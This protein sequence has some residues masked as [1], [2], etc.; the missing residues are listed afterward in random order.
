MAAADTIK[1]LIK[2]GSSSEHVSMMI[3]RV[4]DVL[5]MDDFDIETELFDSHSS[6]HQWFKSLLTNI[7]CKGQNFSQLER[8]FLSAISRLKSSSELRQMMSLESKF[9]YH[10]LPPS[11]PEPELPDEGFSGSDRPESDKGPC[12]TDGCYL[13][14]SVWRFRDLGVMVGSGIGLMIDSCLIQGLS[15]RTQFF[16]F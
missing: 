7:L 15:L 12:K 13:Q 6:S 4:G 2:L 1:Q 14:N 10:S 11:L 8:D 3:H 5:F 9:L 16:L